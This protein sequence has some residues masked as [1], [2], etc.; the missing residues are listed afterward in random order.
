MQSDANALLIYAVT[1]GDE[2]MFREAID[3]GADLHMEDERA[4]IQAAK[5]GRRNMVNTLIE[6]G[7]DIHARD[8]M[9]LR[10]AAAY[11]YR[12]TVYL[13][14]QHGANVY[15]D[16]GE[17]FQRAC[18]NN[19]LETARLLLRYGADL[20]AGH[21]RALQ[22]ACQNDYLDMSVLLLRHGADPLVVQPPYDHA[23]GGWLYEMKKQRTGHFDGKPTHAQCFADDSP[24]NLRLSDDVLDACVRGL[25]AKSI[26]TPLVESNN[27]ADRQ[28]FADIWEQLPAHWQ[29]VNQN[30]YLQFVKAG[31]IT[32][33]LSAHTQ[34]LKTATQGRTL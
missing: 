23:I 15:A 31:G 27:T 21:D 2:H 34:T 13:L 8:D 22:M 32:P 17:A 10:E 18:F 25:F 3:C 14:L 5:H 6:R 19:R 24:C 20:H 29:N 16:D 26:G 7:A 11:G 12:D 28:L 1:A 9:A 30:I 33:G 4:L